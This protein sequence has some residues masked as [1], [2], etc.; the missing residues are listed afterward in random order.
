MSADR[1]A[2]VRE[3]AAHS[4]DDMPRLVYADWLEERGDAQAEFIRL[5]CESARITD[6]ARRRLLIERETALL[7][8]HRAQWLRPIAAGLIRGVFHRGV[9]DQA[10]VKPRALLEQADAWFR[11]FPLVTLQVNLQDVPLDN[12]AQLPAIRQIR[13]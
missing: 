11:C 4:D 5:Q 9:L 10:E 1:E 3:I 2:L 12:F 8:E 13:S 7:A 6:P